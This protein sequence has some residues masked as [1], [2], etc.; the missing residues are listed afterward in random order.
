VVAAKTLLWK[1]H[2]RCGCM[3]FRDA[4]VLAY[5]LWTFGA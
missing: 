2:S 5:T 1:F 3:L 4:L